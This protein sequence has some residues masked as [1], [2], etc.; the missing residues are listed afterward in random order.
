MGVNRLTNTFHPSSPLQISLYFG[1][2]CCHDTCSTCHIHLI[3]D[4]VLKQSSPV[5][6]DENSFVQM[7]TI[8][9]TP[10]GPR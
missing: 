3:T 4:T 5:S 10:N 7:S 2:P 9:Q 1:D 6:S 8:Y